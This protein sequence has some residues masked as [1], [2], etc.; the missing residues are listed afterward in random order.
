MLRA[1]LYKFDTTI[2]IVVLILLVL[3]IVM[4]F[5]AS[6]F[7]AQEAHKDSHYFLKNHFYKV[8]CGLVL[9]LVVAKINYRFW[10]RISPFLLF[11]SFCALIFLL[12][13]P[14][15]ESIRGSKRWL[16]WGPVQFQPSDFA[17][18]AL[19]LFLCASLGKMVFK[20]HNSENRFVLNLVVISLV[21]LPIILQP[22]VG[23]AALLVIIAGTLIFL[24]GEKLR[25][26]ILPGLTSI[27]I[28][29]L[30]LL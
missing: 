18:I 29:L 16:I 26:I 8:L 19:I 15:V 12:V 7:K 23:T 20:N 2:F 17:R 11:L 27:S 3:G 28:F 1:D 22:D 21:V 4:V 6:S 24:A 30:I 9:M 25:Y 13:S 5:S 10:L 14:T